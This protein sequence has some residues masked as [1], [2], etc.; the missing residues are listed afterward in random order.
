MYQSSIYIRQSRPF[1][2][3][4]RN[5]SATATATATTVAT[6]TRSVYLIIALHTYYLRYHHILL[7]K[8]ISDYLLHTSTRTSTAIDRLYHSD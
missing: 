1:P 4:T 6:T 5:S 8:R 3:F 7:Y 2:T